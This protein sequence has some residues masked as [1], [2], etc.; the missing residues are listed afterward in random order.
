MDFTA[1]GT[2]T[3]RLERRVIKEMVPRRMIEQSLEKN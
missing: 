2:A 1:A 3:E